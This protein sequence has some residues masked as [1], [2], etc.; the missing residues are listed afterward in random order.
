MKI[1]ERERR[2]FNIISGLK[3]VLKIVRR[4]LIRKR[5]RIL[6]S[7]FIILGVLI[8]GNFSGLLISGYF[9]T[10]DNPSQIAI[11]VVHY[12]VEINLGELKRNFDGVLAENIKIP[13]NYI[14]GHL[15]KTEKIFIDIKFKDYQKIAL[16]RE[17]ALEQGFLISS[18]YDFVPAKIRHSGETIYIKI[19]LKGDNLDHLEG[20]KWSFRIKVR[21]DDRLFGMKTF[22]IQDPK[23]RNYV[24]EL[25]YHNVLKREGIIGLRYD[26]I[27][28]YVN[29]E[30][31]G[32]YAIEEHFDKELIE[33]NERIEGVI[34]KFNEGIFWEERLQNWNYF[35][36]HFVEDVNALYFNSKIDVFKQSSVLDDTLKNSQFKTSRYLLESFRRGELKTS[37]VFDVEKLAKYFAINTVMGTV[38]ASAWTNL[39][40]Y[41]NPITSKLEPIGFDGNLRI[42]DEGEIVDQYFPKCLDFYNHKK[43]KTTCEDKDIDEFELFFREP[44]FFAKYMEEL[45]KVLNP[46]YLDSIFESFDKEIKRSTR[47]IQRDVPYYHF[48]K[49]IFYD[50]QKQIKKILEKPTMINANFQSGGLNSVKIFVGNIAPLPLIIE[51]VI[52][53]GTAEYYP[54]GGKVILQPK[55]KNEVEYN[56][57]E[58]YIGANLSSRENLEIKYKVFGSKKTKKEKVLPWSYISR[59]TITEV[60]FIREKNRINMNEFILIDESKKTVSVKKGSWVFDK[61]IIIPEGFSFLVEGGTT[62]DLIEEAVILSYSNIV[63]DGNTNNLI[64]IISS[65]GTGQGVVVINAKRKSYLNNV[66]FIGL[67]NP[68]KNN[69][70]P[71]G[72]VTFY[73]SSV[74]IESTSF[75]RINAEDSLN[76]IRSEFIIKNSLFDS[77]FSDCLDVDF[78]FGSVINT[79]FI[80]CGDDGLDF[81]GSEVEVR[82][83][84]ILNHG[85]KGISVGEKSKIRVMDSFI[86]GGFIGIASK[87]SSFLSIEKS[88]IEDSVYG[89][90]VYQKKPEFGPSRL[91]AEK[92]IISGAEVN[93][94]VEEDSILS[95]D[96]IVISDYSDKVYAILYGET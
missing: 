18:G 69:W 87:D 26:F 32:I 10:F 9:G 21:G 4:F 51:S 43:N 17:Q 14:A 90:S 79:R 24:S 3:K 62:I 61:S 57:I 55:T 74:D 56:E 94:I 16:K 1:K 22:S 82:R 96:G 12:F 23:T 66:E 34:I 67:N 45:E 31:K 72:A 85:D 33:S 78:G 42:N 86:S 30:N 80:N 63:F 65:D 7:V 40:F 41:Y 46:E 71:T 81:S 58:F 19:R 11:G 13:F 52:I 54:L 50:N 28:V 39:R 6:Y 25:V 29:G 73:E 8:L 53:N 2:D 37:E 83:V 38:H 92:I 75:I 89:I 49:E 91:K 64:K 95:F 77:S 59:G 93:Y 27:N 84:E 35:N 70:E 76:I 15:T 88:T 44:E 47:I 20:A 60:D 36:K 48:F 5:M 68:S